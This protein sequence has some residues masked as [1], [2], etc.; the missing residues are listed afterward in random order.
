MLTPRQ[1]KKFWN[2]TIPEPN[3]GC[4]LWMGGTNYSGYGMFGISAT[5][6]RRAH[7]L[8]YELSKGFIFDGLDVLHSCDVRCCVNPAHLRLGTQAENNVDRDRRGRAAKGERSGRAVLTEED[9]ISA[10]RD[11]WSGVVSVSELS[12][13]LGA[14]RGTIRAMLHGKTWQHVPL[15]KPHNGD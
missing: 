4:W 6:A 7:R 15:E 11:Y 1:E 2:R 3:T 9:V 8:A 10:R 5:K 12:R 14:Q 13:R